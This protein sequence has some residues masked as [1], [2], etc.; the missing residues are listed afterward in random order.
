[1]TTEQDMLDEL[2]EVIKE[3]LEPDWTPR[4]AAR[5]VI[6]HLRGHGLF[7]PTRCTECPHGPTGFHIADTS[8][9][10]GPNNCFHCEASMRK[11]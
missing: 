8:M 3:S 6:R 11:E 5:A 10:S 4:D 9:E 7:W 2:T 1:M